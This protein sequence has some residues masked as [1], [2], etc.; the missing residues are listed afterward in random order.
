MLEVP[1][2]EISSDGSIV[3]RIDGKEVKFVR[4]SDLGAV[5]AAREKIESELTKLR[6]DLATA[7]TTI[8][9][10]HQLVLKEQA[11][12]EKAEAAV[13]ENTTLKATVGELTSKMA[14]LTKVSGETST[15]LTEK[16]RASLIKNYK[17]DAEKIKD[18][19][20]PELEK[21]E[22]NLSL[23]GPGKVAAN[24]DGKGSSNGTPSGLEGKSPLA[25]AQMGYEQSS[26]SSKSK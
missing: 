12:R 18:M 5:R 10:K 22:A 8:D 26:K 13:T 2:T 23:V 3:T 25:L 1:A 4:E 9:E 11:A 15:K 20:L 6:A 21:V 16:I 19:P 7:N 24:Y 14:D 17:I